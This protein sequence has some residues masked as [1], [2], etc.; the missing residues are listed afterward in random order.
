MERVAALVVVVCL[1]SSAAVVGA[2]DTAGPAATTRGAE[3]VGASMGEDGKRLT[4]PTTRNVA[5]AR[6]E[7][8]GVREAV[9]RERAVLTRPSP[10]AT[11]YLA[12]RA[13]NVTN[14]TTAGVGLDVGGALAI[15]AD[16]TAGAIQT[17]T[18][19][20]RLTRANTTMAQQA[21]FQA[22]AA[23]VETRIARL[24]TDQRAAISAYSDG[25]RSTRAFVGSLSRI[26]TRARRLSEAVSTIETEA[27]MVPGV[28]IDGRSVGAWAR[29]RRVAL[30]QLR[31]PVRAAVVD[32]KRNGDS[33]SVYVEVSE[34]DV[35]LATIDNG[36]YLREAYLP[37]ARTGGRAGGPQ[38]VSAGLDVVSGAYPWA[39]NHSTGVESG[40]GPDAG[41]YRFTVFHQRG[42]LTTSLDPATGSIFNE[43]QVEALRTLPTMRSA[44]M[45]E[46]GLSLVVERTHPTGPMNVSVTNET[47]GP[48]NATLAVE[49]RTVGSIGTD[50]HQ[51]AITPRGEINVTVTDGGRTATVRFG[52]AANATDPEEIPLPITENAV[53][54]GSPSGTASGTANETTT[55][56][57]PGVVVGTASGSNRAGNDSGRRSAGTERV[58]ERSGRD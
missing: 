11:S 7:A 4:G 54:A 12:I 21:V 15:D 16:A 1:V 10:N 38:S 20:E 51:W 32:A 24:A 49:G 8:G 22:A 43:I 44:S 5:T 17:E 56:T 41:S 26:E 37:S 29:N 36:R 27:A 50:G 33:L 53:P 28:A 25:D 31:S 2:T 30:G 9:G 13:D 14:A 48:V 47:G 18:I 6:I 3:A 55:T 35:V 34:T 42:R 46:T 57:T 19:G 52:S 40:G 58:P 23:G 45:N 39:W